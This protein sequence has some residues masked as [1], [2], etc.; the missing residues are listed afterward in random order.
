MSTNS[1]L[2]P[3]FARL[4]RIPGRGRVASGSPAALQIEWARD[5]R[6][7]QKI[8]AIEALAYRWMPKLRAMRAVDAMGADRKAFVYVPKVESLTL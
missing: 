1:S 8:P 5:I 7:I 6:D 2:P 4:A 3:G